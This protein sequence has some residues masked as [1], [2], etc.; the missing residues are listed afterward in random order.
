MDFDHLLSA[1]TL[2][3]TPSGIRRVSELRA[4]LKDPIDLSLGQPSEPVPEA[5]KQAAIEAIR[6]DKNGYT[7]TRGIPELQRRI[8]RDLHE[9]HGWPLDED[10]YGVLVVAGTSAALVLAALATLNA[11]DNCVIQDPWFVLYPP[12]AAMCGAEAAQ[13]D[14]YPD[15]RMTAARVA[16]LLTPRTK[17]VLCC[18]PSNPSG[19]T[20]S[21]AEVYD[22]ADLCRERR[23][24]M[25]SD[26]I[27]DRFAFPEGAALRPGDAGFGRAPSPAT[28]RPGREPWNELLLIRGFG[29]T[30]G[31][32]GWRMGFVAGPNRLLAEMTKLNQYNFVCAPSMAQWGCLAALDTSID[33]FIS[34]YARRRDMVV[35]ALRDVCELPPPTGAFYA[36]PRVPE[37]LGLTASD[38]CRKAYERSVLIVPGGVFSRRDT[39]FRL[40]YAAPDAMLERG[41]AIIAD[42]MRGA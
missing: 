22:L 42:L 12:L 13:C 18:S 35:A 15:F 28:V 7:I 25:I 20:L 4:T 37:R 10:A 2:A 5:V 31:C 36:F 30:Y 1:R 24:L 16:P 27:Y 14:T 29:K 9:H 32:T 11:G 8:R 39:H 6:A 21:Q 19:V 33:G 40:S 38:F 23:T 17:F 34:T 41:L 26:E 3:T